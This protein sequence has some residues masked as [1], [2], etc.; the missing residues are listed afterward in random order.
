MVISNE[1]KTSST[2]PNFKILDFFCFLSF[3]MNRIDRTELIFYNKIHV[4]ESK[5]IHNEQFGSVGL[6]R[7]LRS[8][9]DP[10]QTELRNRVRVKFESFTVKDKQ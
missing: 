4:L 7:T 8:Q 2:E 9:I 10:I 3:L 6:F 5:F 1:L